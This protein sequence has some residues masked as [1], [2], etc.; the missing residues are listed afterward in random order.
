VKSIL[1]TADAV[2]GVWRYALDLGAELRRRE[3]HTTVA[4]MGPAP[5]VAQLEEATRAGLTIVHRDYRLEWM[6]EPWAD[7]HQASR[8]LLD[9]EQSIQPDIIHLNGYA[10]AALPW[11]RR[12][13]V[14]AHSCVRSWWKAVKN[15]A[16]PPGW[17]RYTGAV[18]AGLGAAHAVVA[19]TAAMLTAL[20]DEY[21]AVARGRVIPNGCTSAA[22]ID[23][24]VLNHKEPFVLAAGRLWD[25][26]KNVTSLC[27]IADRLSWPV[28]VAG[29]SRG[30][31]GTQCSLQSV[32]CLGQLSPVALADWYRRASIYALPA[33]YEPFG[34]SVLE[35][36]CAGCALVLGDIAS[37]RENW[38]GAAVFVKPD[39]S[40]SLARTIQQLI[41]RPAMRLALGRAAS[42]R[43][44]AFT[45]DRTADGYVRAYES[46]LT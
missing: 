7:V 45:I 26:A 12:V 39:E 32:Q 8:W 46:L 34:L 23:D 4:V 18:R 31:D 14:V 17:H 6:P 11:N 29:D 22:R 37:L 30:P 2:G 40:A 10:H 44:S 19:P 9:L 20:Q 1:M 16:A 38:D 28:Y 25:E 15:G 13:L 41:D 42:E 33:R 43:A 21:G 5:T 3:L 27:A 35:A 36:A 24:R